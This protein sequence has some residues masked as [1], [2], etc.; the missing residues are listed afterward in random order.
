MREELGGAGGGGPAKL[1]PKA[2]LKLYVESKAGLMIIA[3]TYLEAA[4]QEVSVRRS[5]SSSKV[6][7]A[8][9]LEL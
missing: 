6:A 8:V 3:Q 7:G 5:I 9:A 2:R 4:A 1:K